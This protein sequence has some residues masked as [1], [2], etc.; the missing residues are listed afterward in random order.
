MKI[1]ADKVALVTGAGS[2]IGLAVALAYGKEGAKVVV[3]DIN[4][5]AGNETVK[6]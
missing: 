4:E 6:Q 3:S 1:L 2:G 5:Q